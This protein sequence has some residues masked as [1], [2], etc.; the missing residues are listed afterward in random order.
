M[1]SK[2]LI[3]IVVNTC[4]TKIQISCSRVVREGILGDQTTVETEELQSPV[5]EDIIELGYS[6]LRNASSPKLS[7][8]LNQPHIL[9]ALVL[10]WLDISNPCN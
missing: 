5:G 3:V 8:I 2:F 6:P 9:V 4:F 7:K 1:H 10:L